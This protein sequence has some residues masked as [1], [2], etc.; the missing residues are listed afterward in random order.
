MRKHK[1]NL[2]LHMILLHFCETDTYI[3]SDIFLVDYIVDYSQYP[4][5]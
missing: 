1:Y 4:L 3:Q 2:Q 5:S